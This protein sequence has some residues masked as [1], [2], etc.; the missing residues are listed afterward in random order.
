MVLSLLDKKTA[1]ARNAAHLIS[2]AALPR[3]LQR[4]SIDSYTLPVAF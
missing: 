1:I 3:V 2:G 4:S